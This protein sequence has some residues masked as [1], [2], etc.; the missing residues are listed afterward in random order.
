MSLIEGRSPSACV[1]SAAREALKERLAGRNLLEQGVEV[2]IGV[3]TAEEAIGRPER[4]DFPLL[5]GKER[6]IEAT[7]LSSRGHAFTDAPAVFCGSLDRAL[8]LPLG[9]SANRAVFVASLNA[10]CR[11][12]G[13]I[14]RSLHCRDEGPELC[15]EH[16]AEKLYNRWGRVHIGLVGFNPAIAAHLSRVF[17]KKLVIISDRNPDNI[18]QEKFGITVW[19][20]GRYEEMIS[21]CRVVLMTGTTFVNGTF[22]GLMKA[23]RAYQ[24]DSWVYGVTA[25]GVAH[26][27]GLDHLCPHGREV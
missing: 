23:V 18:G 16:I 2:S 22:D 4:R 3:L 6:M 19:D 25:A 11:H 17:G 26:L 24:R 1:L 20:S 12:L 14:Q 8:Q 15:G 13:L 21:R 10:V 27:L 5:I 9:N 7:F